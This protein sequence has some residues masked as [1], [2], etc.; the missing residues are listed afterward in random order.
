MNQKAE[1]RMLVPK[2]LKLPL[3]P[4]DKAEP[5]KGLNISSLSSGVWSRV[6][7]NDF[8]MKGSFV[9]GLAEIT[10]SLRLALVVTGRRE[11][12]AFINNTIL[13]SSLFFPLQN[14]N[15]YISQ[16]CLF[17]WHKGI[18]LPSLLCVFFPS[19]LCSIYTMVVRNPLKSQ[20]PQ[21]YWASI[22]RLQKDILLAF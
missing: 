9:A 8:R 5:W 14:K 2:S 21:G 1:I 12:T 3:V 13:H 6:W 16:S 10:Q 4:R 18:F 15:I 7:Y 17:C 22:N 11:A 19:F 20:S